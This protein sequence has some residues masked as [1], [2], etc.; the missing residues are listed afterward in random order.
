MTNTAISTD[1]SE[2][3]KSLLTGNRTVCSKIVHEKINNKLSIKELY[4]KILKTSLYEIGEMWEY[5]KISV[6][7]EHLASAIVEA[8]LNEIYPSVISKE[9]QKKSII[10]AC[11]ENEYHQIGIK[12]VSD[13]FELHG[14]NSYF[15]GANTPTKE[16][17]LFAKTINPDAIAISLSIY[18]HL[19]MLEKMIQEIRTECPNLSIL[20]GGQAF[21]K[22]GQDLILQW[23]NVTY[24]PDLDS[25]DL[26]IENF[27]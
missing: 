19:P 11:V 13:I 27:K 18:F 7:T 5:N 22:G 8:L 1:Y 24:L 25:I 26:Y 23:P 14:W 2:F 21:T 20:V 12:M 15:L 17:V 6:A 9:K 4:E 10:V 16:L 3:L